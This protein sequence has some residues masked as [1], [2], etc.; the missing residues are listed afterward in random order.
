MALL[1]SLRPPGA[2]PVAVVVAIVADDANE[3]AAMLPAVRRQVYESARVVVVGGPRSVREEAARLEAEWAASMPSFLG[4]LGSET[5]HVWM[6]S[7]GA[8]PRPDA[9]GAL[10]RDAERSGASIAGSKLLQGEM[11]DALISVGMATDVFNATY[12]GIDPGEI[13]QGQ[14]DVVRDV[15]A[16]PAASILVRRDLLAGLG[17]ID[18]KLAPEAAAIDLCQRARL[19]G[20]R[21]IVSPSSE[22]LYPGTT[23]R[24]REWREDAGRI[25][26]ILKVYGPLTLTWALPTLFLIGLVESIAS[27]FVGRWKL[28]D[29]LRAWGWNLAML[30]STMTAR[31][32][33]RRGRVGGDAE[34]FRYQVR[35]S[36]RLRKIGSEATALLQQR[37]PGDYAS[38]TELGKELRRPGFVVGIL[39]AA[40]VAFSTRNVWGKA[41]PSAGYSLPLPPSGREA[42]LAYAGGW[43]PAGLGGPDGLP[44]L[45]GLAG[46]LQ[47][48]L[49][50]RPG[51]TMAV[52]VVGAVLFG[53]WGTTRMLR[54]WGIGVVPGV[55]AGIVL[56][57]GPATRALAGSGDIGA[58]AAVGILPWAIRLAVARFPV[59]WVARLGRVASIAWVAGLVGILSPALLY[60]P[61]A[62]VVL[63][64]VVQTT[65]RRLWLAVVLLGVG[66]AVGTV[67]LMPWMM[68]VD[69][70]AYLGAGEAFWLPGPIVSIAVG[71][72]ALGTLVAASGRV[73]FVAG[74]GAV[75]VGVGAVT[76]R[77]SDLG[78]GRPIELAGLAVVALGTAVVVAGSLELAFRWDDVSRNRRPFAALALL[79]ASVVGVASLGVL[80]GGRAGLPADELRDALEFVA[81][82]EDDVGESRALLLGEASA[83]PGE[84][85]SYQGLSYRLVSLPEPQLWEA[86]LPEPGVGD[87][88][89][90]NVL[91]SLLAGSTSRV[92]RD[93]AAFG[94]RWIVVMDDTPLEPL[95]EGQLDL[96][97]L[98]GLER[99]TYAVDAET[100]VR[101]LASDGAVWQP[102]PGGYVGPADPNGRVRLADNA[103]GRWE[104]AWQQ[105]EWSNEV[106]AARGFAGYRRSAVASNQALIAA[107]VAMGLL[108]VS[109]LGRRFR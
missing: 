31:W 30:P 107:L 102:V 53:V 47:T 2:P 70:E 22:A 5:T 75:L 39:A 1:M 32:A 57:G 7:G 4:S 45:V 62:A 86:W 18:P 65:S 41:L 42:A 95:F 24:G 100:S 72:A 14:Y 16:V 8:R 88:A 67:L 35:G 26:N 12:L 99:L 60:V 94:I 17:G 37:L 43:N 63:A 61:L 11:P 76:A 78:G 84:S 40:F 96:V 49:F 108:G 21:I 48:A 38:V 58:L 6:V 33:A 19:R 103:N 29:W 3:L 27:P 82:A 104:P 25:R 34:L 83:L 85:R 46:V 105:V 73:G 69:I 77:S 20:A 71:L 36:A 64:A 80:I 23:Q 50:D 91:D 56:M 98:R 101:A 79:A 66:S 9:L 92:G 52:I 109:W 93:L 81:V 89:F 54:T 97:P 68:N 44:P 59:H 74:W 106:S 87:A 10:V 28:F 51:L 90:E 55:V 15:A 13:D